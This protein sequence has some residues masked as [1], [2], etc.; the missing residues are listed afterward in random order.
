MK[1]EILPLWL[2]SMVPEGAVQAAERK[3]KKTARSCLTLESTCYNTDPPGKM[4]L[5]GN[6]DSRF[7]G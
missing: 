1:Q 5:P 2:A 4:C 6:S 3:K 7:R